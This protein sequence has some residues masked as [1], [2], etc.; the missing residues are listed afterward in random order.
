MES[1][2]DITLGDFWGVENYFPDL[3]MQEG[4]SIIICKTPR[5]HALLESVRGSLSVLRPAE[6]KWAAAHN[7]G[8]R[9]DPRKNPHRDSFFRKLAKC[10]SDQAAVNLMESYFR[11]KLLAKIKTKLKSVLKC[12]LYRSLFLAGRKEK[13]TLKSLNSCLNKLI[14][15]DLHSN[16]LKCDTFQI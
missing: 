4:L 13:T 7:E 12:I 14:I 5:A 1:G 11:P 3:V 2:S 15:K 6:Y 10:R 9:F 16:R 8:L